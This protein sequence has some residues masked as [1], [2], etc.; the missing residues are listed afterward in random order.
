[1]DEG[2][3]AVADVDER[4]VK[5]RKQLLY[6]SQIDITYRITVT[7]AGLL[8]KFY[9]PV[10]FHQ[11]DVNFRCRDIDNEIFFSCFLRFHQ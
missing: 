2:F 6:S 11:G 4:C 10:V 9:Q 8:V 3:L 5:R 1:M 7:F